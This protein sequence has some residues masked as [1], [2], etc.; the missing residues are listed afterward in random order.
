M[1][2][3]THRVNRIL[4]IGEGIGALTAAI[5]LRRAGFDAEVFESA[6][7]LE[8][9]Q[10]GTAIDLW[11]NATKALRKLDLLDLVAAVGSR[12]TRFEFQTSRG[13]QLCYWK[14]DEMEREFGGPTIALTRADFHPVLTAALGAGALHLGCEC[15]SLTQDANGVTAY[16]A[17]GREER[18]DL[19]I[20]ADGI[21]SKV[22]QLQGVP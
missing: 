16:F 22:R 10:V 9:I 19:L 21:R 20:G 13:A 1:S 11:P 18:G 2:M 6:E 4:I 17:D 3:S 8:H 7:E 14:V 5:A 15:T 12:V